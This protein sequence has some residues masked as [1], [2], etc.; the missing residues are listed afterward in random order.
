MTFHTRKV[1]AVLLL[2]IGAYTSMRFF[3]DQWEGA[4]CWQLGT[5]VDDRLPFAA[6]LLSATGAL[7]RQTATRPGNALAE[8]LGL[9][10]FLW[11]A[12]AVLAARGPFIPILATIVILFPFAILLHDQLTVGFA[13]F[14]DGHGEAA[15]GFGVLQLFVMLPLG[16]ILFFAAATSKRL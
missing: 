11:S 13:A 2:L 15:F 12:L 8:L 5:A 16:I 3:V 6:A 1:L 7:I 9:T 4:R 10:A 14:C